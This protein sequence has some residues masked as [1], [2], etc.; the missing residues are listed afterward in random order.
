MGH[1]IFTTAVADVY[2]HYV[3]KVERKGRTVEELHQVISWLTGYDDAALARH[4]ETG[5]TFED[6]FA[7]ADM[8]ADADLI[9]GSVCGVKVQEVEDPLMKRIR[10]LDKVVDELAKGKS[11][12]KVIRTPAA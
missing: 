9:T 11:V 2:P 5:T 3:A 12:G 7:E 8:T 10:Q 6:F 4:L 1:R